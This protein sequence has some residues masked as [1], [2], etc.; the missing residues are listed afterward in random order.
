VLLR[1]EGMTCQHCVASVKRSLES[2]DAVEE[3]SPDLA[4]GEVR[5]RGGMLDASALARVVEQAGFRVSGSE[6]T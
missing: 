5:V 3:A 6:H 4:S 1:V 2:V